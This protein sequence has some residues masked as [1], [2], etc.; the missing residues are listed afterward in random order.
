MMNKLTVYTDLRQLECIANHYWDKDSYVLSFIIE[1]PEGM[2]DLKSELQKQIDKTVGIK[3]SEYNLLLGDVELYL[4]ELKQVTSLEIRT[5]HKNWKIIDLNKIATNTPS[6]WLD[7]QVN[8][9]DNAHCF[10]D[11][12]Y[13]VCFDPKTEQLAFVYQNDVQCEWYSFADDAYI[14]LDI[15]HQLVSLQFGNIK[16]SVFF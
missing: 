10:V 15:N 16:S 13:D 1:Y 5:N 14:G 3:S 11:L 8:F 12:K 6:V 4:N 7:F 9:D 2:R